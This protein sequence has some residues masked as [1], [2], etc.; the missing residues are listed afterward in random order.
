MMP[1]SE[2]LWASERTDQDADVSAQ[3]IVERRACSLVWDV[4]ELHA[5]PMGDAAR[6]SDGER[7]APGDP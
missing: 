1:A 4:R 3:Q 6:S 2:W 7:A 5:V